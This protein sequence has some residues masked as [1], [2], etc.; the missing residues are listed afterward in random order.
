MVTKPAPKT[1]LQLLHSAKLAQLPWLVHAFSTRR[2]GISRVY[3]GNALNLGFTRHD[4]RAAVERN[5]ALFLKELG[6]MKRRKTCTLITLRQF[7]SDLSHRV[8]SFPEHPL[9]GDGLIT[10]TP[11]LLLAVQTAD[12]LPVILV[13]KKNRAVG[14]FHAGWRGAVKRIV[15]KGVGEMH[16]HFGTHP[17]NITAS[18]GPGVQ[19]CCYEVSEEVRQKFHSQFAYAAGL[20]REVKES[21]PVREKYPLLFL[22]ARAP[23]HS[24][25]PVKLFLDL[26]EANRRQLL[27]AG[28][29]AKNI[30]A[31]SLCTACRTDL[32]FSHRTEKG[33]T[34]R[35]MGV[36]GIRPR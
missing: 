10:N 26:V 34:G 18:I 4:T 2:G 19:G 32:F 12:C 15:E 6:V 36:V 17:R 31:S 11:G 16:R 8:D 22:T 3:G 25:L 29:P 1:K 28:V 21:D 35:L 23:G 13:D 20:F 5:R 9:V 7:H 33:V 27:D 30:D 24:E 14:I